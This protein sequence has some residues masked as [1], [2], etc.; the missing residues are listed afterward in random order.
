[1]VAVSPA[2]YSWISFG[3]S[4]A[5]G[6]AAVFICVGA[7]VIARALHVRSHRMKQRESKKHQ[8]QDDSD[9]KN[10]SGNMT[11]HEGQFELKDGIST[12][13]KDPDIIPS[14]I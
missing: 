13:D 12:D 4:V 3:L 11:N 2:D 9:G 6:G 7:V 8:H 1:M 14:N 5:I 10:T